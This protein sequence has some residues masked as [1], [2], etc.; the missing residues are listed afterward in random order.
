MLPSS[1]SKT[2]HKLCQGKLVRLEENFVPEHSDDDSVVLV[3]TPRLY[4]RDSSQ[5]LS[6]VYCHQRAC[7]SHLDSI[8]IVVL[9]TKVRV[10]VDL[11]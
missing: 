10:G 7:H 6:L 2:E 1:R 9:D 11:A 5:S 8:R 3:W 4:D